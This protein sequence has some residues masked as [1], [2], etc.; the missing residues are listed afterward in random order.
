VAAANG[1]VGGALGAAQV[2]ANHGLAQAS[3]VLSDAATNAFIHSLAGGCLLAG[4]VA[5]AGALVALTLLPARPGVT[6][7][8]LSAVGGTAQPDVPHEVGQALAKARKPIAAGLTSDADKQAVLSQVGR[9]Q[10]GR[11]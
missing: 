3:T 4:V 1:S 6:G 7:A 11:R 8:R 5:L 10:G 9:K 2:L